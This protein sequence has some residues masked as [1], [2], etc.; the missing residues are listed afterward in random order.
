MQATERFQI[1][2]VI[3]DPQR[4]ILMS[5]GPSF[6]DEGR[7]REEAAEE[8]AAADAHRARIESEQLHRIRLIVTDTM[9]P[10]CRKAIESPLFPLADQLAC[11]R[12][13]ARL[14]DEMIAARTAPCRLS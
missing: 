10:A 11:E 9:P 8:R 7:E 3:L 1:E 6:D 13:M 2:Q 12:T 4:L 5:Y 14:V